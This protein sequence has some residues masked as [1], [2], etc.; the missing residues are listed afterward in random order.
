MF[1][2][3]HISFG[4]DAET[5]SWLR[6]LGCSSNRLDLALNQSSSDVGVLSIGDS[7]SGERS[8]G[9]ISSS[10]GHL[11]EVRH[12]YSG[13][14]R[15]LVIAPRF[16][17]VVE[18]RRYDGL[19]KLTRGVVGMRVSETAFA[20][21]PGFISIGGGAERAVGCHNMISAYPQSDP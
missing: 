1:S 5:T 9:R 11:A 2:T 4:L 14:R 20:C 19:L 13:A 8:S 18:R 6:L 17:C 16:G 7:R 15:P 21:L 12:E 10:S 3:L